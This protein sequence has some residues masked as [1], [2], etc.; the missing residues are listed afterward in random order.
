MQLHSQMLLLSRR[1][2]L[3]RRRQRP[4]LG[5]ATPAARQRS[6]RRCMGSSTSL[7]LEALPEDSEAL[8]AQLCLP[9][10]KPA[11]AAPAPATAATA[12]A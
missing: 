8:A 10:A 4:L 7:D 12:A 5:S 11:A 9:P 6:C 2:S 1:W 3:G